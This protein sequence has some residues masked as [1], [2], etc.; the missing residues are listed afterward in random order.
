MSTTWDFHR[1]Y[2]V[3]GGAAPPLPHILQPPTNA[4]PAVPASSNQGASNANSSDPKNQGDNGSS[5]AGHHQGSSASSSSWWNRPQ[6]KK[7]IHGLTFAAVLLLLFLALWWGRRARSVSP[8]SP[9]PASL[10]APSASRTKGA[11]PSAESTAATRT[12]GTP[13]ET[14]R[15]TAPTGPAGTSRSATT[16]GVSPTSPGTADLGDPVGSRPPADGGCPNSGT[17]DP[18]VSTRGSSSAEA[19][20]K[21]TV[22][23]LQQQQRRVVKILSDQQYTL[24]LHDQRLRDQDSRWNTYMVQ[25]TASSPDDSWSDT[26]AG[27]GG[28]NR[29]YGN[30]RSATPPRRLAGRNASP[31]RRNDAPSVINL[32]DGVDD[33]EGSYSSD[34][35]G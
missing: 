33:G 11:D 31:R 4:P 17:A 34:G 5:N 8:S 25:R 29:N 10:S 7:W 14:S 19:G 15:S 22:E 30:P 28:G 24:R 3:P 13:A 2:D 6:N 23:K 1:L 32:R 18:A 12:R 16:S 21:A 35:S 27:G 9:H 20:L 26:G